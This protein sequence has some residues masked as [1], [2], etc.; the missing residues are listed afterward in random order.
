MDH[1][2]RG[3]LITLGAIGAGI[4]GGYLLTHFLTKKTEE[5]IGGKLMR[6]HYR[7]SKDFDT[8]DKKEATAATV[9]K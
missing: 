4:A 3:L 5:K 7:F 2:G 9:K 8:A 6:V 1:L